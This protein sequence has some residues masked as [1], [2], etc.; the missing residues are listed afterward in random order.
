MNCISHEKR[1]NQKKL[2][3]L[4]WLQNLGE[5][6]WNSQNML[7]TVAVIKNNFSSKTFPR[8]IIN[9]PELW[10]ISIFIW[11][12]FFCSCFGCNP[13]ILQMCLLFSER[14]AGNWGQAILGPLA[15]YKPFVLN[16]CHT[17]LLICDWSSSSHA[18]TFGL[19]VSDWAP[20]VVN[21]STSINFCG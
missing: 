1:Q 19:S 4:N 18:T 10:T 8:K 2:Y 6:C 11:A 13:W 5:F 16:N 20:L 15:V 3:Y 7:I 9:H 12:P 14:L 21:S 17:L